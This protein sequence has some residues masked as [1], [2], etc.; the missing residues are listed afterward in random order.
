[1]IDT[2]F[3]D[4]DDVCNTLAPYV[5]YKTGCLIDPT[6]YK[7]YPRQFGYT[8]HKAINHLLGT[9]LT[10]DE[11]W[12]NLPQSTWATVPISDFFH[13]LV[14][15]CR[16]LVGDANVFL[17]TA[18]V[19]T[20]ACLAGKMEWILKHCPP[21][22]QGQFSITTH[23]AQLARRGSL[24]IDDLPNNIANFYKQNGRGILVPR[25]WNEYAARDPKY[26]I[27]WGLKQF[28]F[29]TRGPQ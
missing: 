12:L 2:I 11:L 13:W 22:L 7:F 1:M 20:P 28:Q 16:T 6:S 27:N 3:L 18:P 25:P 15:T 29:T 10:W 17:A 14:E 19:L 21:W 8:A 24:L 23:K 26:L 4:L 9:T 5:L